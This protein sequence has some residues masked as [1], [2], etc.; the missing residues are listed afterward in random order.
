MNYV[1]NLSTKQKKKADNPRVFG[2]KKNSNRQKCNKSK[3]REGS[4][5]ALR[6]AQKGDKSPLFSV[7]S[8]KDGESGVFIVV[9]KT[10]FPKAVIRNKIKRRI[11][12]V[13]SRLKNKNI[14]A[15]IIVNKRALVVS[16]EELKCEI[17][18]IFG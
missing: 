3:T 9:K 16:F 18:R 2:E 8:L 14:S 12:A 1:Q 11:K 7:Y 10:I 15:K 17:E 4:Q 6:V 13:L 5:E